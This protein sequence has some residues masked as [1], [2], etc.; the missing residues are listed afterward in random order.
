M[1]L[2]A[3]SKKVTTMRKRPIAGRYLEDGDVS[4]SYT[5]PK[6]LSEQL[7]VE[8]LRGGVLALRRRDL[9]LYWVAQCI[10]KIFN[11]ARLLSDRV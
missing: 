3:S 2:S 7:F 5:G 9:R 6:E 11:L 1:I 4:M 10:Q 8:R